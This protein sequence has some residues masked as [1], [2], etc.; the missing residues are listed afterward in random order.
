MIISRWILI[1]MGNFSDISCKEIQKG[2]FMLKK[3]FFPKFGR[4]GRSLFFLYCLLSLDLFL[5]TY[6]GVEG[7]GCTWTHP[8]THTHKLGRVP[9]DKGSARR[10][11]RYLTTRNTHDRYQ[12]HGWNSNPQSQQASG[13]RHTPQ[14]DQHLREHIEKYGRA[15]QATDDNIER[16]RIAYWITNDTNKH[17]DM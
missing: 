3:T 8:M 5:H 10:K 6:L 2:K 13:R 17:S 7:C 11:Y 14:Q 12:C 15:G 1:R 4:F 9:L 16:M